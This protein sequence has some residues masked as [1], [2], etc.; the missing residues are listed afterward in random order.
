MPPLLALPFPA[1][2]PVL[3][4][5]GPVAIR[6][7]ALA[8]IGGIVLAWIIGLRLVRR[9]ELF[10]RTVP[11]QPID[12]DDFVSWSVFGIIIGG[13]L[14]HVL[15][16]NP[17]YYMEHP[18]EI[19]MPW[20]GGMAFHGGMAGLM[21]ATALFVRG[22]A[23]SFL[24]MI[25]ILSALAPIGLFFG[26][27]A[28][29]INDELWGRVTDVPWAV[30]FPSGDFLPRHPSQLYEAGLEGLLLFSILMYLVLRRQALA[31][32]G[33]IGCV[34]LI[35]YGISRFIVEFVREPEE[36]SG[37][38]FGWMTMGQMLSVPMIVIGAAIMARVLTRKEAA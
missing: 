32:P 16:Y 8:Y 22:R 2:D 1:I 5:L 27:I 14:A 23:V 36:A 25:D 9:T 29:F 20:K 38:Y 31:K 37:V 4:E 33:L 11:P 3:V 21:V 34:F 17:Q 7:Y 26:R 30:E 6:W 24:T 35:G 19:L 18:L 10:G 28:N 15:F 12:L 13:R